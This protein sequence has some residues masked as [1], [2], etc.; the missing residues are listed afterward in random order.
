MLGL[1]RLFAKQGR[2][3]SNLRPSVLEVGVHVYQYARQVGFSCISD[4]Y[5]LD[6]VTLVRLVSVRLVSFW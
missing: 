6:W 3:D 2:Q 4:D 1:R 5:R